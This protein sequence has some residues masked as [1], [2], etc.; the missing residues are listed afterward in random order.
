MYDFGTIGNEEHYGQSTP[1]Q[2]DPMGMIPPVAIFYGSSDVLVTPD[3]VASLLE[4]LPEPVY[5][6]EIEGFG[7]GD[8]V[9]GVDANEKVYSTILQLLAKYAQ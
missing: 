2:Y 5:V 9:W 7:H 1:P 6:Q 3:S 4:N 8:F